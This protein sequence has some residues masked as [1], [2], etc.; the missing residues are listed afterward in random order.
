MS[1]TAAQRVGHFTK[2]AS[3]DVVDLISYEQSYS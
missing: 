2:L 1:G 3:V